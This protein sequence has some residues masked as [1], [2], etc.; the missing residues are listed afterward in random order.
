MHELFRFAH[1]QKN[2]MAHRGRAFLLKLAHYLRSLLTETHTANERG[3]NDVL[4]E[5]TVVTAVPGSFRLLL[6][7]FLMLLLSE[8][9]HEG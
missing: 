4:E 2:T 8:H 5:L 6:F 3:Y 7:C 9:H 1:S